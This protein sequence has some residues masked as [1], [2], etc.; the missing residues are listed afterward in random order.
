MKAGTITKA[1][2]PIHFMAREK[3]FSLTIAAE[4]VGVTRKALCNWITKGLVH[5][6]RIGPMQRD[7]M[8]RD[9]RMI[10]LSSAQ[11]DSLI[12]KPAALA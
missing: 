1:A 7:R 2:S 8:G 5:P 9:R 6:F 10:R 12:E 4:Q 11:I 3:L